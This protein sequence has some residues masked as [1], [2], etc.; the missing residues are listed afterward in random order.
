MIK[1]KNLILSVGEEHEVSIGKIAKHIAD[2]MG[3]EGKIVFDTSFANGQYKKTADNSKLLKELEETGLTFN[4]T[5]I[6][7]GIQQSVDWFV[8]NYETCRK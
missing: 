5:D 7:F 6:E 1:K 2:A 8:N 4:F 3:Y